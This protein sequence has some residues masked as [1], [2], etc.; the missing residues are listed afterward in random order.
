MVFPYK[1]E[2]IDGDTTIVSAFYPD[3]MQ[4][5]EDKLNHRPRKTLGRR[6]PHKLFMGL[7][8]NLRKYRILF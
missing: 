6:T 8:D 4:E 3:G 1:E 7:K 5:V 2:E